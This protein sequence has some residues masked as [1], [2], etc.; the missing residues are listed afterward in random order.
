MGM[1]RLKRPTESKPDRVFLDWQFADRFD[2]VRPVVLFQ[3]LGG[4]GS[5]S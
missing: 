4:V 3:A 1:K 5:T 2:R